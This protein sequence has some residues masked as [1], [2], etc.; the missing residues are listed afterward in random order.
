MANRST[1]DSALSFSDASI[2]C[3]VKPIDTKTSFHYTFGRSSIREKNKSKIELKI[4][5]NPMFAMHRSYNSPRDP[6][7][8][9]E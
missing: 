5:D 3:G 2:T 4:Q 1:A 8:P 7:F 6:A 9:E